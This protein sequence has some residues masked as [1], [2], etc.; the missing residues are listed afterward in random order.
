MLDCTSAYLL[1]CNA[2]VEGLASELVACCLSAELSKGLP[3][4]VP[5]SNQNKASG[6]RCLSK[7][8]NKTEKHRNS[9]ISVA[10]L[11]LC[12]DPVASVTCTSLLCSP[13][14]I[15]G[16]FAPGIPEKNWKSASKEFTMIQRPYVLGKPIFFELGKS[17]V[18]AHIWAAA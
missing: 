16:V 13:G 11:T 8:K 18:F 3:R 14:A 10:T 9:S 7:A 5:F 1:G 17:E 2:G 15:R 6:F 12:N 4:K